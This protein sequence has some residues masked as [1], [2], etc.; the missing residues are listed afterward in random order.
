[1]GYWL[2]VVSHACRSGNKKDSK[3]EAWE[4]QQAVLEERRRI[5]AARDAGM[6]TR[7]FMKENK[8]EKVEKPQ[9]KAPSRGKEQEPLV[10][11]GDE[12]EDE[13]NKG[14]FFGGLAGLFGKK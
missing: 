7:K 10:M 12:E 13:G 8:K 1:M 2:T 6:D 4:R 14:G 5:K 9:A 3:D 11:V